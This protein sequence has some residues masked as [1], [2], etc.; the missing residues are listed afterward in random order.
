MTRCR[1][2]IAFVNRGKASEPKYRWVRRIVKRTSGAPP[3]AEPS[4][5]Q[6]YD[7]RWSRRGGLRSCFDTLRRDTGVMCS[8]HLKS[9][10]S[11]TQVFLFPALVKLRL[12]SF[13]FLVSCSD[14]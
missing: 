2:V 9:C 6:G 3:D 10:L 11:D 1:R 5:G 4:T 8:R 12:K 7:Q 13:L 14:I